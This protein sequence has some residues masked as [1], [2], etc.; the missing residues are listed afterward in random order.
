MVFWCSVRFF[1]GHLK[2]SARKLFAGLAIIHNFIVIKYPQV[3]VHQD[4]IFESL[5]RDTGFGQIPA[6]RDSDIS[7]EE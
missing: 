6:G 1:G 5:R 2:K 4:W 3:G 7:S